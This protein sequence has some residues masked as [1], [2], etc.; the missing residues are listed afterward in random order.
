MKLTITLRIASLAFESLFSPTKP[1][2]AAHGVPYDAPPTSQHIRK[3]T[4]IFFN[5]K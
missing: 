1:S 2:K 3:D 5:S 4:D